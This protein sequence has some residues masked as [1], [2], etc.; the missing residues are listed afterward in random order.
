MKLRH[1]IWLAALPFACACG[2]KGSGASDPLMVPVQLAMS[3]GVEPASTKGDASQITEMDKTFRGMT[4]VT[5]LPF[6]V[7]RTVEGGDVSTFHPCYLPDISS[8]Y[9]TSAVLEDGKSLINGLVSENN[10]HLYSS[11]DVVLPTGTSAVLAYGHPADAGSYMLNDIE[12]KHLNGALDASGLDPQPTLRGASDIS[13]SPVQIFGSGTPS[14]AADMISILN[15]LVSGA[16]TSVDF[17]YYKLGAWEQGSVAVTWNESIG[18]SRLREWFQYITNN[19]Q[20]TTGSGRNVAHMLTSIY[21]LLQNYNSLDGREYEYVSNSRTYTAYKAEE[22]DPLTYGDIY[23][24]LRSFLLARF[25]TLQEEEKLVISES[26]G[27]YTVSFT[28]TRINEYPECYGLPDGVAVLRWSGIGWEAISEMMNGVAPMT[29]Y[30]Y[31]PKLWYYANTRLSTSTSDQEAAYVS[32]NASWK[33]DILP[34][35]NKEKVIHSDTKSAALDSPM[36]FSCGMLEAKVYATAYYMDDADGDPTSLV[37]LT[38]SNMPVTG[39]II[40]SHKKLKFDFTPEDGGEEYFLYDNCIN[41]V[42]LHYDTGAAGA[43]T[44]KTLVSQTPEGD[45]VYFCLELRNNTGADFTGADGLVLRGAKFYLVGII[46]APASGSAFT[47]VFQKGY[48]TTI[49]CKVSSLKEARTAVPDLEHPQLSMG[50][51]VNVNWNLTPP[52]DYVLY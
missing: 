37:H 1:I 42:Y 10:A 41:G 23:N 34:Y 44:F 11:A 20:L 12:L 16:S 27:T 52:A 8:D 50:M 21:N 32:T 6:D 24:A 22:G 46:E 31:P 35:Y 3:V 49:T 18:D 47:S 33:Y 28:D 36:Q 13:F 51:Q 17:H 26:G 15:E 2:S 48:V 43:E 25:E 9:S 5:V 40:G 7:R 30:C 14:E 29:A 19:G 45:P 39:V 38:E 4:G